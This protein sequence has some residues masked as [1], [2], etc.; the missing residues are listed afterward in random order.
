MTSLINIKRK[1]N[2]LSNT[3][4]VFSAIKVIN[5]N[6]K[7]ILHRKQFCLESM[8]KSLN[9]LN[10]YGHYHNFS[11]NAS[12]SE[13][14]KKIRKAS[15]HI[16]VFGS[17]HGLCGSYNLKI[18]NF[19]K[20]HIKNICNEIIGLYCNENKNIKFDI[21]KENFKKLYNNYVNVNKIEIHITLVGKKIFSLSDIIQSSIP[22]VR[23]FYHNISSTDFFQKPFSYIG[24][25][26]T[27]VDT[28]IVYNGLKISSNNYF[29]ILTSPQEVFDQIVNKKEEE[30]TQESTMK[31]DFQFY[32]D[33]NKETFLENV[34]KVIETYKWQYVFN[35][36]LEKE[37]V[38][39]VDTLQNS[40]DNCEKE[41]NS[42]EQEYRSARQTTITKEIAEIVGTMEVLR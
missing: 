35:E 19:F 8:F 38:S 13:T 18:K 23:I 31:R 10:E 30:Q 5:V 6:K 17:D 15:E 41:L 12:A 28:K 7:I 37:Y 32:F 24:T 27:D 4:R 26:K 40:I 29:P 14:H 42:K 22:N 36:I 34:Q 3:L 39:R 33:G 20:K 25:L 16:L 1:I 2:T 11:N 21:T 9:F